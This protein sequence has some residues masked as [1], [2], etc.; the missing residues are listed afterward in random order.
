MS[1]RKL[2]IAIGVILCTG[3]ALAVHFEFV[4]FANQCPPG[5]CD[6]YYDESGA[7]DPRSNPTSKPE[8]ENGE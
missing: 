2:I 3:F 1:R 4:T 6:E 7:P 5:I 8:S